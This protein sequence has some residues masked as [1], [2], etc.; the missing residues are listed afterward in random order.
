M[1]IRDQLLTD[2]Q[3]AM[4]AQD[5]A[6]RS[7]LRL[8]RSS[9]KDAEIKAEHPLSEAEEMDIITREAKRRREDIAEYTLLSRVDLVEQAK[10]ELAIIEDYLPK[11]VSRIE[12]EELASKV[13]DEI[14]GRSKAQMGEAMRRMMAQLKNRADSRVVSEVVREMLSRDS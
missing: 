1:S 14:G 13:I 12:I 11:Q 4:K 2:L 6:R 5:V 3:K 7:T 9:I 10:T 8:L